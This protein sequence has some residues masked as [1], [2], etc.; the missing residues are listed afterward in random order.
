MNRFERLRYEDE[1]GIKLNT[2][3]TKLAEEMQISK[4]TISKLESSDDYDA[5]ISII[6]KYKEKFPHVSYDYLLGATGTLQ[7]QYSHVEETLPLSNNFY[8]HLEQLFTIYESR[9]ENPLEKNPFRHDYMSNESIKYM[10]EAIVNN[11]DAL[12]DLLC[13]VFYSLKELYDL[14]QPKTEIS[15]AFYKSDEYRRNEIN[16]RMTQAITTFLQTSVAPLLTKHFN[17]VIEEEDTLFQ[18]YLSK[19]VAPFF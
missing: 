19:D 18:E 11:P 17:D 5:R 15:P 6:R 4:A 9:E 1:F 2:S 16:F 7:K 13:E 12:Y 8:N 14:E 3:M 10:L